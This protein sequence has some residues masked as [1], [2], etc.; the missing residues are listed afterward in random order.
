MD[1]KLSGIQGL[2][3]DSVIEICKN[4][5]EYSQMCIDNKDITAT[6]V[7]KSAGYVLSLETKEHAASIF[8]AFYKI[9]PTLKNTDINL[10]AAYNGGHLLLAKMLIENKEGVSPC[11]TIQLSKKPVVTKCIPIPGKFILVTGGNGYI[12]SHTVFEL[13]EQGHDVIVV[14]D[15]SNSCKE[16][17]IRVQ[18][19]AGKKVI[20]YNLSILDKAGL[21]KVFET[22]PIWSVIH[23]AGF[24]SVNESVEK[25][26]MYYS[27]NT[28]GTVVLLECMLAAKCHNIVFS[29]SATVYA[30]TTVLP[31]AETHPLGPINPYGRS[32]L[33]C[34]EIIRDACIAEPK[35][36]AAI[37][38]YFNPG[39][40][41]KSARIG[42][43]PTGVP[44]NLLP[45]VTQVLIG[46]RPEL[47]V[48]GD[49]YPTSQGI[50]SG[51]RDYIFIT[52]LSLA[53]TSSLEYLK[54]NPGCDVFNI[55]TG[56]GYSVMQI[57][58]SME[59]VSGKKIKVKI[60]QRRQGDLGE[61]V[62][63]AEKAKRFLGWQATHGIDDICSS[64]WK[65]QSENPMGFSEN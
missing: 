56:T 40:A 32:K 52:D 43:N 45:Y 26:L 46:K 20:I 17:L 10:Q 54:T 35:M 30:P 16:S 58:K 57:V 2:S 55:G 28:Y 60:C 61:V 13:L 3:L 50:G 6:S 25:P 51:I 9:D 4:N 5:P 64:S 8:K 1:S 47:N 49:D 65:W 37:L 22:H 62:A 39:G 24:K 53:H 63:T 34:E 7:L 33:M 12:G 41:H 42:E 48:F 14:D 18:K 31:I 38:R 11:N 29:S 44:N 59:C 15:Y 36:N 21:T 23:F 19:L 27:N